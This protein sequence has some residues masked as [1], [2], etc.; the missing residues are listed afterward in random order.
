MKKRIIIITIWVFVISQMS[1]A[2]NLSKGFIEDFSTPELAGWRVITG[3][4]D[5]IPDSTVKL[6]QTNGKGLFWIDATKDR[7]NIWWAVMNHEITEH[8]DRNMLGRPDKAIRIEAKVRLPKPRRFNLSL[9][10]TS[11]TDYHDDLAEFD[12]VDNDW[13]IVSYTNFEFGA[14]PADRIY[15]QLAVMDAGREVIT[16]ELDY[17]KVTIVDAATASPDLGDPIPYRPTLKRPEDFSH[18]LVVAEDA[19]IN[20][21]YTWVNF[22][23]WYDASTD[24]QPLLSISGSQTSILRWDFSQ[25]SGRKP[26]GWGILVLTT[27]NVHYAPS[28]LEEFG[29]IRLVEI[30]GGDPAWTRDKVSFESLLQGKEKNDVIHPQLVMDMPPEL[31]RG[32]KTVIPVSPSVMKRLFSGKTNGLAIYSQGAVNASFYSSEAI[33]PNHRPVLYFELE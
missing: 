8:I 1:F 27:H 16:V 11:T 14:K 18:S 28:E 22:S 25:F 5:L 26:H 19:I 30:K 6:T 32:E 15:A 12:I 17:F 7:R 21:E 23:K 29:Y 24:S 20:S 9:N 2:Q 3:S 10:H 33:H 4:G 31:K 13:Q